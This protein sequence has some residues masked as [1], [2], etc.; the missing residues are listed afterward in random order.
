M[1]TLG[2]L[3]LVMSICAASLRAQEGMPISLGVRGGITLSD[4]TGDF[5]PLSK[6]QASGPVYGAYSEF[7]LT[8]CLFLSGEYLFQAGGSRLSVPGLE[9]NYNLNEFII[10]ISLKYKIFAASRPKDPHAYVFTGITAGWVTTSE[11][12]GPAGKIGATGTIDLKDSTA[13]MD[14]AWH[15][16]VGLD[17]PVGDNKAITFDLRYALGL[18]NLD[19]SSTLAGGDVKSRNLSF[20]L[21]FNFRI[22]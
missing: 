5:S 7:G 16:G 4:N 20:V 9:A 8:K 22:N 21:G 17:A 18:A 15:F 2:V 13:S 12:V 19:K 6:S 10:P 3:F 1:K 11:L 14:W